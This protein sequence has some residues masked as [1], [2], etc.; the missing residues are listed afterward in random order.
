MDCDDQLIFVSE[1][2]VEVGR[3]HIGSSAQ[4]V[5]GKLLKSFFSQNRQ[6]FFENGVSYLFYF[7]FAACDFGQC[8]SRSRQ[9]SPRIF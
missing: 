7:F 4:L 6:G 2:I 8:N 9:N 1:I 3:R 5:H